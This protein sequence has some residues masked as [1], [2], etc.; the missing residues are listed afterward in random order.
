MQ[1]KYFQVFNYILENALKNIF[2]CLACMK[3]KK[4]IITTQN[5]NLQRENI[6][7]Y[8]A[9]IKKTKKK[10]KKKK[11]STQNLNLQGVAKVMVGIV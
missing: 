10:K 7:E 2:K 11:I 4:K 3:K 6:F 8:M 1:R 5:L 9:C